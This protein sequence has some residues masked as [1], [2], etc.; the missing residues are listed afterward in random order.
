[1]SQTN[2]VM[3]QCFHWYTAAAEN[4]WQQLAAK[5]GDLAGLG[6]TSV[7][8][9]PAAKAVRGAEDVGY[10]VYD[11]YDLGEFDQKGSVRTKYGTRA[12]YLACIR[13]LQTA[14][15]QVYADIVFNHR[16]GAD[17]EEDVQARRV[18][19]ADR[20]NVSDQVETVRAWTRFTFPG[21][22]GQ[23]S[24][25]QWHA[26]HFNAFDLAT[27]DGVA[28]YL[29]DGKSF[30]EAVD[31]EFG[32]YDF[33]MGA[34]VDA[35]NPQVR[36]ELLRWGH[37]FLDTT[38]V[39]GFRFDAAKHVEAGFFLDWLHQ[40]RTQRS[41]NLFAVGEYWSYKVEDLH[42]FIEQTK[43]QIALFDAPLHLN[44]HLASQQGQDYDL[45]TIFDNT[46]VQQQPALAVTLVENHDSQPLQSLESVVEPWFKP[47]AYALIL[48]REQGYPCVFMADLEGAHY[49]DRDQEGHEQEVWLDRHQFL[50]ER[51]LQARQ[52]WA[53][54]EQTD[55]FES[56]KLIGW[57]RCGDAE[58]PGGLAVLI[59]NGDGGS[60]RMQLGANQRYRDLTDH[61]T[62]P[63][64]T[65]A[66]GWA[67]F[68]CPAGS[69]A[70]W[71]PAD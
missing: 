43:G 1:M 3:M 50:I 6:V 27:D 36:D 18:D 9:P 54:G 66:D 52:R 57:T 23:Y 38:G 35:A 12:D 51:Y 19:P 68:A 13:A 5:A 49:R 42:Q 40:R 29:I 16:M 21:R 11:L 53:F 26:E 44:F 37:W 62:E 64:T 14:G 32:N 30:A 45:R 70:V 55:H 25:M 31:E 71:V 56:P 7:W 67:D 10:G 22:A 47:L 46:L 20:R 65:D 15:V 48:L 24:D 2:G 61:I 33:L 60:L 4:L 69:V 17:E 8:L 63:V 34:N 59:A 39:D 28:I 58:H 41:Q